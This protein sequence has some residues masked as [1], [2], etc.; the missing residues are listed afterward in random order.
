MKVFV[1]GTLRPGF[2]NARLYSDKECRV[3]PA[4]MPGATLVATRGAG[5]PFCVDNADIRHTTPANV[6]VKGELLVFQNADAEDIFERLDRLEG[7]P[8]FYTRVERP[9]FYYVGD[10]NEVQIEDTAWVYVIQGRSLALTEHCSQV[11]DN[12]WSTVRHRIREVV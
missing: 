7:H 9:L 12:D 1:Y 10:N 4:E 8:H 2:P 5:F 3:F 6:P 11:R